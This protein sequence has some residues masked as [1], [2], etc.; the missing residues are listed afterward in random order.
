[1]TISQVGTIAAQGTGTTT[2]AAAYNAGLAKDE[3]CAFV[4]EKPFSAV[5]PSSGAYSVLATI[6][7]GSVASGD[8]VGSVKLTAMRRNPP[9]PT[10]GSTNT[11]TVGGGDTAQ[12]RTV[13]VTTDQAAFTNV[14]AYGLADTDTSGTAVSATGT[15][16]AGAIAAGDYLVV[17]AA[18]GDDA[19]NHS[20]QTLTV[21]G[22]TLSL[23]TAW[24]KAQTTTGNDLASYIATYSVTAGSSTGAAT[25]AATSN[26]SG[27]ASSA[28]QVVRYRDTAPADDATL[29]TDKST[30]QAGEIAT[31]TLGG[32]ETEV[33]TQTAGAT[34][35]V[36]GTGSTRQVEGPLALNDQ[37][38]TF[39]HKVVGDSTPSAV[40]IALLGAAEQVMTA[41]GIK[42]AMTLIVT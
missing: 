24:T 1:M 13:R 30:L 5:D 40:N 39:S 35:T 23:V 31:L 8:G 37:T 38:L 22:C 11:I 28:V 18:Y 6:T 9:A 4:V 33:F 41:S 26:V 25:Y 12:A 2:A 17:A 19:P 34:A 20:A 29:T 14:N 27:A 3:I 32:G 21:A 10:T 7:D 16:P 42:P 15:I 36:T